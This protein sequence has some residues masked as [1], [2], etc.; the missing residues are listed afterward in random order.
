MAVQLLH[1]RLKQVGDSKKLIGKCDC[2]KKHRF[3]FTEIDKKSLDGDIITLKSVYIC[4]NCNSSYDGLFAKVKN[5]DT[6]IR[7]FNPIGFTISLIL[8]FG[9]LFGGYKVISILTE[10]TNSTPNYYETGDPKDMT[11]KDLKDY[12]KWKLKQNN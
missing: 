9:L 10:P 4:P 3:G 5:K 7:N 11:D 12:I 2:G 6:W 1:K 8:L